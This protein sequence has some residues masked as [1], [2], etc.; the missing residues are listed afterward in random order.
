MG[1]MRAAFNE[2]KEKYDIEHDEDCP[3][4]ESFVPINET[5]CDCYDY[6]WFLK[7][8]EYILDTIIDSATISTIK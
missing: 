2:E 5:S 3:F 7:G 8:A 1:K 4:R 6:A